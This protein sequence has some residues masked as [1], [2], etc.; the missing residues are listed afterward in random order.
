MVQDR[1][2]VV[3]VDDVKS[4]GIA[5]AYKSDHSICGDIVLSFLYLTHQNIIA[6]RFVEG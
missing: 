4:Q 3:G 5:F 2:T 6:C 1:A